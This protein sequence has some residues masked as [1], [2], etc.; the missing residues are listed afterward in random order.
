MITVFLMGGLGN[1]LFQIFA[2]FAY[3]IQHNT[4]VVFPYEKQLTTGHLRP[5]YWGNFLNSISIFTTANLANNVSNRDIFVGST[6]YRWEEHHYSPLP[7]YIE[8][9]NILLYGYFQS[10]KYF[11]EDENQIMRLMRIEEQ[12]EAIKEEFAG[13]FNPGKSH[14][15]NIHTISMHFRM[16]DYK[17]NA[18]H[19][20]LSYDY[21]EKALNLIIGLVPTGLPIRVLY[22][23][24][25][26]DNIIV[27]GIIA[28]LRENCH[29]KDFMKVGDEVADWKQMLL[30]SLCDSHIIANS[31]FSWW[32]AYFGSRGSMTCYP[33]TWFSGP[34]SANY[35][36]DM[37]PE[38][39]ICVD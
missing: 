10:P 22:F 35:M 38:E 9:Q 23:C 25:K 31:T 37:F 13:Y 16:G 2:A 17:G 34:L 26:E 33:R 29:I 20:V 14:I 3:A 11:Q 8:G 1:Q 18:C 4:K 39:W 27:E 32:G 24:E 36:G 30:M 19:P 21:Y 12:K 6:Q 7:K 5:T 15:E 28:L